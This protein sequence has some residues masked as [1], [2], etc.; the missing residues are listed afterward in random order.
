MASTSFHEHICGAQPVFVQGEAGTSEVI[1]ARGCSDQAVFFFEGDQILDEDTR[2]LLGSELWSP[3][4]H[5]A[6]LQSQAGSETSVFVVM[7][8]TVAVGGQGC[9][10]NFLAAMTAAGEPLGFKPQDYRAATH[11]GA[12]LSACGYCW[13]C[14]DHA[15]ADSRGAAQSVSALAGI[16]LVGFSKGAVVVN[17]LLAEMAWH[18]DSAEE[19]AEASSALRVKME[20]SEPRPYRDKCWP[21]SA[22]SPKLP[23]VAALLDSIHAVHFFDAG[24]NCRGVHLTDPRV[25]ALL[26]KRHSRRALVVHLHGTPRQWADRRRPW[27]AQERDRFLGLLGDFGVPAFLHHYFEGQLPSLRQHFDLIRQARLVMDGCSP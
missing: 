14:Q 10:G 3:E 27:I 18:E 2:D 23:A 11:L 9:Y 20:E 15:T 22:T 1:F 13:G 5:L 26:G 8:T 7:P 6:T 17:Q 16:V 25:T 19:G 21:T 4:S 12:I 24:L